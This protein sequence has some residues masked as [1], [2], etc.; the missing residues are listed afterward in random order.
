MPPK[1]GQD[2]KE[3]QEEW[4]LADWVFSAAQQEEGTHFFILLKNNVTFINAPDVQ[5]QLLF[6]VCQNAFN[7]DMGMM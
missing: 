3:R 6:Q 1:T 2:N 4:S 5:D 7:L